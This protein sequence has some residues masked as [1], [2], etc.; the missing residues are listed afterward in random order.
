[1]TATLWGRH[2]DPERRLAPSPTQPPG[3]PRLGPLPSPR[4]KTPRQRRRAVLSATLAAALGLLLGGPAGAQLGLPN[5]PQIRGRLD[6]GAQPFGQ[7]PH[8]FN[9]PH[10][11]QPW[12]WPGGDRVV[13]V[14]EVPPRTVTL[15]MEAVQPGSLPSAVQ[16]RTVTLP[17]YRV[18]ETAR[19]WIVDAH[20]SVEPVGPVY[21]WTWRPARFVPK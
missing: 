4:R 14:V 7:S 2:L 3:G 21:V 1:M 12:F 15:P 5:T 16:W 8:P 6:P 18:T 9:D 13:R 11:A 17:G 10:P 19:G 20:W